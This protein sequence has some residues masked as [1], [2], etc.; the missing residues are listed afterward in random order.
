MSEQNKPSFG[1]KWKD[2]KINRAAVIT[3]LV[4]IVAI[5]LI[6]SVTIASN[7]AK[8][9]GETPDTTPPKDTPTT[10]VP[11]DTEKPTEQPKEE[12]PQ[13]N[14]EPTTDVEDKLPS[15]ILPVSGAL[16]KTHD[17]EL[18][19]FSP[20]MNDYRVHLGVDIVTGENA[21][22]YAAADGTVS[23]I[24]EDVRMG[25]CMA[26]KHSGDCYTIYKNL[27]E[28]LPEGIG[29]GSTVRSGQ[30]IASVGESAMV[31]I[32]DE[33]HLHFEMTVGDLLVDPLEYFDEKAL[34]SLKMDASYGE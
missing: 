5:V 1:Q 3:V 16:S 17:T 31:E 8:K 34:E 30:L 26:I 19:V 21:P 15:F 9:N 2:T 11:K 32:A 28:T 10:E 6:V 24:W 12:K 13:Q 33:P 22:V 20:T 14:K 25:Y 29:V 23:R 27:S 18:Q 7:R 4:L